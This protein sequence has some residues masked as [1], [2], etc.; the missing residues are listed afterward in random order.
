LRL[1]YLIG[2]NFGVWWIDLFS[3]PGHGEA[4]R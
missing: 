1:R 2:L 3:R 4:A